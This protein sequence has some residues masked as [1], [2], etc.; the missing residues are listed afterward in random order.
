M[1]SRLGEL[2]VKESIISAAQLKQALEHQKQHGGRLGTC[3]VNL[4]LVSDE[5]ITAVLSRQ[6]GVPSINLKF[7]EVDPAVIKLV[8]QETAV[9]YQ[10][11][12][13]SR[14]GST[15]TIAMTDPTNVFAMDDI[16]FMTGFNVE[17]VV[18][19]ESA[20]SEAIHKF[21]GEAESVE[22]LD[23]VMKDLAGEEGDLELTAEEAEMDLASL[24]QAAEEAPI[25][26]L[27]NL[28]LT[29]AVKRGAS[30][31]HVEP[32]EKEYRVRFRIDGILQNVMSPPMKLKD[33]ISSRI[34]IMS[35]LDISEKR[36]PQDGRIMIKYVKNGKKK[37]LDFRVSTVPALFGEK[38][39]LRLLDKENL[40]L[41]MTKLGFEPESLVKFERQILKP[42]GM[43]LV[44]G[45]TGS[46]KT[47]TL[48]SSV[49]RLNTPET[50]IMTAEDPV[51]FQLAGINQVQMKDQIGLNFASALRAFLRQDPNIILVGEI[52]DFETAE[53]AVK[54]SLTGHLVLSTLHTNDAPSTISRLMNM[55]IEP[56]LVAT[57]VNLICAQRLV[58]RICSGCKEQLEIPAQ[59]LLDAG[60]TAEE[61]KS[62][63]VMHGRGCGTCNNTGYKGRVGLYEVMEINDELRELI[64]V[65]AS[66]LEL[67]KKAMENGMLTL[68]RS[69]LLKIAAGLTSLEEVVRETV[70]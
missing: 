31:I 15:L 48:Y 21:Y 13:L 36:L 4:G 67:K 40:R 54:A 35:K 5:D 27:V 62:V 26:K 49:A 18:A 9:R 45:P 46:G 55:G 25:I 33:A 50:N 59:A 63:K 68:R 6:Y 64:L 12:P 22:E 47:N 51:E 20:I 3:L 19:S 44:T 42:Y 8:P 30:D 53:I 7:Y 39:V 52:R 43:V 11:V 32:Y 29:D 28:I 69:G 16:K 14:V 37:E 61:S 24:E 60:Y 56:F 41:D 1:S 10:I 38:I 23:K 70:L 17:P 65:G 2:L 57:S 34:K 58:R 66:A